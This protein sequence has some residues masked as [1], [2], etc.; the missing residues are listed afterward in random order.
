MRYKG[1]MVGRHET[2]VYVVPVAGRKLRLLGPRYPHALNDEPEMRRRFEED[3]YKPSWAQPWPAAVMLAEHVLKSTTPGAGRVLELGAGLGIAGIALAMAGYRVVVTDYDEDALAFVGASV[4]LNGA[5][6]DEIRRLD[7]RRPPAE[8]FATIVAA[9]VL[10]EK[11]HHAPIA[12]LVAGCLEPEGQAFISDQ[13]RGAADG[14]PDALRVV[15]LGCEPFPARAKAIPAF[16][17]LD[18]RVFNGTVYRIFK[19]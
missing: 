1:G 13:N 16:D 5:Q 7:W 18:G 10:Y 3:G 11:R 4:A 8:R 9:D 6:L 12:A 17:A 2:Q 19:P 14:F 15:G